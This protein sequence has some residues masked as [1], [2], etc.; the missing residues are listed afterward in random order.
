MPSWPTYAVDVAGLPVVFDDGTFRIVESL[1]GVAKLN[2]VIRSEDGSY[3]PAADASTTVRENG[4]TIFSGLI[5]EP[6]ER[7]MGDIGGV[8]ILTAIEAEDY[9][10]LAWRAN[11]DTTFPDQSLKAHLQQLVPFIG[12]GVTLDPAQVTGPTI[13]GMIGD[14][15]YAGDLLNVLAAA[16]QF[17]W[18]IDYNKVLRMYAPGTNPAPF[19]I[20]TGNGYLE[21]DLQVWRPGGLAKPNRVI[22]VAGG[23]PKLV[24]ITETFVSDGVTNLFTLEHQI[25]GW[26]SG[27]NVGVVGYAH[28]VLSVF[29]GTP[30]S[31]T[32]SI[33]HPSVPNLLWSY[34]HATK[35]ITR[36]AGPL[37]AGVTI[38]ITYQAQMPFTVVAED[39]ADI[40]L[41]GVRAV[42]YF[43][44]TTYSR[45]AAQTLA[46]DYLAQHQSVTSPKRV[47]YRTYGL[48]LRVGQHQLIDIAIRGVNSVFTIVQIDTVIR[49][50]ITVERWITAVEGLLFRGSPSTILGHGNLQVGPSGGFSV[51]G[52]CCGCPSP[53]QYSAQYENNGVCGGAYHI[54][55]GP[56]FQSQPDTFLGEVKASGWIFVSNADPATGNGPFGASGHVGLADPMRLEMGM[57][58]GDF[59]MDLFGQALSGS[60]IIGASINMNAPG[61]INITAGAE[62]LQQN[63][64]GWGAV[65]LT[66]RQSITNLLAVTPL[67]APAPGVQTIPGNIGDSFSRFKLL[68]VIDGLAGFYQ[69]ISSYPFTINTTPTSHQNE[70]L[71]F[72]GNGGTGDVFLPHH[73]SAGSPDYRVFPVTAVGRILLVANMHSSGI[74]TLNAGAAGSNINGDPSITIGP[75]SGVMVMRHDTGWK[76][77][78]SHGTVS[79]GGSAATPGGAVTNVQYHDVGGIFGGDNN[80]TWNKVTGQLLLK[81]VQSY[82]LLKLVN[83]YGPPFSG[84]ITIDI[85]GNSFGNIWFGAE[86]SGGTYFAHT[87]KPA[88]FWHQPSGSTPGFGAEL[89]TSEVSGGQLTFA[90]GAGFW[91]NPSGEFETYHYGNAPT[92]RGAGF[93]AASNGNLSGAAGYYAMQR[94]TGIVDYLWSDASG[95]PR[96]GAAPPESDGTPADDSGTPLINIAA[97]G[98]RTFGLT[99]DG[100][101]AAI[102]TGIKGDVRLPI[103]GTITRVTMLADQTGSAVVDIWRDNYANFPPTAADSITASAKPTISSAN[104]SE[105]TTLTGW[106]ASFAAGDIFRFNVDSA[107]TITRL[108]LI[109]EYQP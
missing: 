48:G 17:I 1:N 2:G 37:P 70:F 53:P 22:V 67:S 19:N 103:G 6:H 20:V 31:N 71:A 109:V 33:G 23:T 65:H 55:Y 80:F 105:D 58:V 85:G 30:P 21:Q 56:L 15:R 95:I 41:N 81:H 60:S 84:P 102:T 87:T 88:C 89:L 77:I 74:L 50:G 63:P 51:S 47:R 96:I 104:K 86:L 99:V 25:M 91:I 36:R 39:A 78:L 13:Q 69:T 43:A 73:A 42:R 75:E 54:L 12:G 66:G 44:D 16:S 38:S 34:D 5:N 57:L 101:G 92:L 4:I 106:S 7:G 40:A 45:A 28:V 27:A 35:Q 14:N 62:T 100:G 11:V 24:D 82:S 79:G 76:V 107:S 97:I 59:T 10:Q 108:H 3:R 83:P 61:D 18:E 72:F 8:G 26:I 98:K 9:T 49:D 68:N 32:E 52:D 94:K 90:G 29:I 64:S 93:K 46:D